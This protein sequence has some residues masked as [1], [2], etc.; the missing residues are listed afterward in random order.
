MEKVEEGESE[1]SK[2]IQYLKNKKSFFD[3]IKKHFWYLF[4][5]LRLLKHENIAD[6]TFNHSLQTINLISDQSGMEGG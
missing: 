6:I 2:K 1:L 4:K 5:G 3:E